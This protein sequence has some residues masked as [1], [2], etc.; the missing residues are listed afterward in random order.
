M[1]GLEEEKLKRRLG[2]RYKCRRRRRKRRSKAEE[3][4]LD[5][6]LRQ[7]EKEKDSKT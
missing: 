5:E 4:E 7:I 6:E 3:C 2:A 1:R